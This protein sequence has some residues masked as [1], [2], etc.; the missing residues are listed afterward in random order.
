MHDTHDLLFVE[1]D[2]HRFLMRNMR[3]MDETPSKVLRRLLGID[4]RG[5]RVKRDRPVA[6]PSLAGGRR[7]PWPH[8]LTA[9]LRRAPWLPF[10]VDRYVHLLAIVASQRKQRFAAVE[11]IRGRT[12]TYFATSAAPIE[13]SGI[14]TQPRPIPGTQYWVLTNLPNREKERIL[15]NVMTLLDFSE[16]AMLDARDFLDRVRVPVMPF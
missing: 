6:K 12:R 11:Q 9:A 3:R 5:P 2:V 15:R 13:G 1:Y 14:A 10:E 7:G 4:H 16:I 8:E